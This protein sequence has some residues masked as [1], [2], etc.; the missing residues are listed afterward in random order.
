[1]VVDMAEA[2]VAEE[3]AEASMVEVDI[4]VAVVVEFLED[5]GLHTLEGIGVVTFERIRV[6]TLEDIEV[7]TLVVDM[8]L[9]HIEV[10]MLEGI[11]VVT[12]VVAIVLLHIEGLMGFMAEDTMV[13]GVITH[14]GG[15]LDFQ[16]LAGLTW[17]GP[18]LLTMVGGLITRQ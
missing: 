5:I 16:C 8:V 10:V 14:I 7:G 9:L 6:V 15:F 1:M 4:L 12:I 3:E 13:P 17:T 18:M 11:G 2:V